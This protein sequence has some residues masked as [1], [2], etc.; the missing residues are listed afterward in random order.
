MSS[1]A[2]ERLKVLQKVIEG[3]LTQKAAAELLQVTTRQVRRLVR[4]LE[5][6]GPEVLVSKKQGKPSNRALDASL[7]ERVLILIE[8]KYT[9]FKPRHAARTLAQRD[10]LKISRETMRRWMTQAGLWVPKVA[11]VVQQ[12]PRR[13]R[14]AQVGELIQMDGSYHNWFEGRNGPGNSCL[15]VCIDDA[16]SRIMKIQFYSNESTQAYFDIM[17]Q[18]IREFGLPMALYTDRHSVFKVNH[19]QSE[20]HLGITDFNQAMQ[21]IGV[22]LI[23]ARS[24]Q[25]KGRVERCNSTLQDHLVKWLRLEGIDSP[26]I[27]NQR[28]DAFRDLHNATFAKQPSNPDEA[29]SKVKNIQEVLQHFVHIEQRTISKGLTISYKGKIYLLHLHTSTQRYYKKMVTVKTDYKGV[30]D[31]TLND[32]P[33]TYSL[34]QEEPYNP[35][36]ADAKELQD[37]SILDL[38][39]KNRAPSYPLP[40]SHLSKTKPNKYPPH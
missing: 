2:M 5:Q 18:Y 24:P 16:T 29:H 9:D 38:V 4:A 10:N 39:K 31:I 26:E 15:I 35:I 1:A 12:H 17:E 30:M 6:Y 7:K 22:A 19:K 21:K 20:Q 23:N 14:R 32:R 34:F 37:L 3:S 13:A 36:L 8:E 40:W 25:A 28:L 33:I 11:K 27:A